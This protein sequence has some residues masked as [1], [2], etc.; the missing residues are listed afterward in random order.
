MNIIGNWKGYYEY[1]EGYSLP[2]FGERVEIFAS[3]QG[4]NDKFI[5]TIKEITS[6]HSIPMDAT[7]QGF[8]EEGLISFIKRYPK[9]PRIKEFGSSEI[10]L[11]NGQFE[12]EHVGM[13]D[14]DNNSIYGSWSI[15]EIVSDDQGTYEDTVYGI[16]LLKKVD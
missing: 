1:G 10:E 16:W 14:S 2:Q 15:S 7:V 6:D 9:V 8:T 13:I 5:G 12:I 11:E 4:N 3:F